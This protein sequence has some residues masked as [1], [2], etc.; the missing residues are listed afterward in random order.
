MISFLY[1]FNFCQIA[2]KKCLIYSYTRL[3]CYSIFDVFFC[4]KALELDLRILAT[5]SVSKYLIEKKSQTEHLKTLFPKYNYYFTK[6]MTELLELF[7][8][9]ANLRYEKGSIIIK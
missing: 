5:I 1:L 9:D 3:F 2:Q 4:K 6:F 7:K 8:K